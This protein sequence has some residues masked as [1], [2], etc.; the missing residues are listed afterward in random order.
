MATRGKR[1]QAGGRARARQLSRTRR[2]E[3]ARMGGYAVHEQRT[4]AE[5]QAAARKAIA[6][7]WAAWRAAGQPPIKRRRRKEKR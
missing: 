3:I 1:G 4:P 5:R 6:A 2:R 7:R